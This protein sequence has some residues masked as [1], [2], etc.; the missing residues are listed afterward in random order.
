MKRSARF[1]CPIVLI[2]VFVPALLSQE[3][4]DL[5]TITRIRYEGFRDSHVMEIAA[6]SD[7]SA[8]THRTRLSRQP[9]EKKE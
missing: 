1:L 6:R 9:L 2:F 5:E 4:V 3:K 8:Q 7:A